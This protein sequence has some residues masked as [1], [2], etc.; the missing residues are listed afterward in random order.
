MSGD[1]ASQFGRVTAVYSDRVVVS[2]VQ[3]S[4]CSGCHAASA[5]T[6]LDHKRREIT[7]YHPTEFYQVGDAVEV[8]VQNNVGIK[9]ILLSF[10]LPLFV[11]LLVA[12]ISLKVLE[13]KESMA[14]L[15]SFLFI[16]IYYFVLSRFTPMLRQK[17]SLS[18]E[19][20]SKSNPQ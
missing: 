20:I 16:A 8:R 15:L 2:F 5:C 19:K 3:S 6:M 18:L 14:I 11:I 10:V 1:C 4:A 13:L 9:A 17:L 12:I 7:I